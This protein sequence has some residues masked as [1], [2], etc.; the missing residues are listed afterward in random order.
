MKKTLIT[1]VLAVTASAFAASLSSGLASGERVTP[2]HPKHV[3][4]A[5]ADTTGCFPCTFQ[6]RP[7][8]QVWVNGDKFENVLALAKT[9]DK[10]QEQYKASEFKSLIVFIV[11]ADQQTDMA[12][13]LKEVAKTEGL[14]NVSMA[15]IAPDHKSVAA[16]KINTKSDVKNTVLFYKNWE[17]VSN[18]VNVKADKAG[19][20][21]LAQNLAKVNA[22]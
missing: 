11:P 1:A 13:K 20:E 2:F 4:G 10:A 5:L 21:A 15:L 12:K 16:Y 14:K 9:L 6:N 17:V 22:D 8:A 7:Q 18:L 19:A 3:V